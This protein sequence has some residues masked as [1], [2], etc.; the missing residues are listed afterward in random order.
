MKKVKVLIVDDSAFIRK[1]LKDILSIDN[2]IEIVD[3]AKNGQEAIEKLMV[4]EVDVITLDVEMPI[5]DGITTLKKIM[6]DKPTPTIMLSSLTQSGADLTIQ[7]LNSGAVD[8][9]T[10]PSNI[11][12][13]SDD[14]MKTLIIDKIKVASKVIVSKSNF[15]KKEVV[16]IE[17]E[18]K[19]ESFS[20]NKSDVIEQIIAIG[21]STGGPRALQEVVPFISKDINAPVVIVQHMP[22]G[23]TKS[24][25]ERLN[26]ISKI[27]VKEAEHG[28]VLKNGV[29]YIAPG[30]K[31]LKFKRDGKSV[32]IVLDEGE[33]VSGHKPSVD[34]MFLSL[35][36]ISFKKIISVIMTG[37]GSDG[38]KGMKVLKDNRN[39]Y[40]VAEDE[41]TCVVFGMPKSAINIGAVDKIL[42]LNAIGKE[43]NKY[44]GV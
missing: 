9:I 37:M 41:S 7:A 2:D 22:P 16:V 42:P 12:K 13:I 23:F 17:K 21:T 44:M 40:T 10:K 33:K 24:L 43:I 27:S 36:E 5:M 15:I 29:A 14:E 30:D 31:H 26:T 32:R 3:I 35:S 20:S 4:N 25:A 11:F 1:M 19:K 39:A 38:S 18:V 28:E 34:A 6:K 8:F